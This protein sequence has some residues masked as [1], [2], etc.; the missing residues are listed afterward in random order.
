ML[1][2]T[3]PVTATRELQAAVL[4]MKSMDRRLRSDVNRM[5]R[6]TFNPVWRDELNKRATT[7]VQRA[8]IAKGARIAAGN[9]PAAVAASS[10]RALRGGLRPADNPWPFEVGSKNRGRLVS[11]TR[12]TKSGGRV[13]FRRAA[14]RQLRPYNRKGYAALPALREVAPR[15]VSGWVQLIVRSVYDA[16]ERR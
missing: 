7:R 14:A 1:R 4:S 10:T 13:T 11:V 2:V 12:R 3:P 5:T 16:L 15:V 8:V 9:P 6:T